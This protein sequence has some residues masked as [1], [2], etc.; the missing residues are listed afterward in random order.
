MNRIPGVVVRG[1]GETFVVVSVKKAVLD[2]LNDRKDALRGAESRF[3]V[4]AVLVAR[5]DNRDWLIWG[6]RIH[7]HSLST[8]HLATLPWKTYEFPDT[9]GY[10][11]DERR[12]CPSCKGMGLVEC[13]VCDGGG[14]W[15]G[16]DGRVKRCHECSE[17]GR[18]RCSNYGCTGGYLRES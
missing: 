16:V 4:P 15:L 17:Y 10:A 8:L 7:L 13:H 14:D 1:Q 2:S 9:E 6:H 12:P 5:R 18:V 11:E 3:G